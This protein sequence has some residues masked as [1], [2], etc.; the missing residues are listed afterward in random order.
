MW[1]IWEQGGSLI[2]LQFGYIRTPHEDP[3]G[4]CAFRK[5]NICDDTRRMNKSTPGYEIGM[6]NGAGH[7]GEVFLSFIFECIQ[8]FFLHEWVFRDIPSLNNIVTFI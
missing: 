1:S 7:Y 3:G 5:R 6:N 8:I 4:R 2:S